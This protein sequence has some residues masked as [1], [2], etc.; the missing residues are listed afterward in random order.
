MKIIKR[1]LL[2]ILGMLFFFF[3]I[4]GATFG[5]MWVKG[6]KE[7]CQAEAE[8]VMLEVPEDMTEEGAV[9]YDNNTILYYGKRYSYNSDIVSILCMGVDQNQ[10]EGGNYGVGQAGRA[11]ALVLAALDTKSGRLTLINISRDSITEINMYDEQGTWIGTDTMQICLAY[12]YGDGKQKSCENTV[13]AV[14]QLF[15]GIPIHAYAA[16]NLTAIE[17]LNDAVGGV[18]VEILEDVPEPSGQLKAGSTVTLNGSQALAYVK[19]RK[20]KGED[21]PVN[22]N[23]YRME[24]QKQYMLQFLKQ[25]FEKTKEDILFPTELYQIASGHMITNLTASKVSYLSSVFAAHGLDSH[26]MLTVPGTIEE[27]DN[28]ALYHVN[29]KALYDIIMDVFYQEVDK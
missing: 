19:W 12:A 26:D 4:A 23:D 8:N 24:R 29:D 3:L 27:N 6:K 18:H 22:A 20:Y 21:A 9:Q 14:S 10:F 17:P 28:Y 15:Y 1:W 5:I 11:D 13:Q 16:I 7:L 25:A 2:G